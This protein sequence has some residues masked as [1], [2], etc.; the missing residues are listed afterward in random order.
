L[1]DQLWSVF[2]GDAT[3]ASHF[4]RFIVDL[5]QFHK[6]ACLICEETGADKSSCE[7]CPAVL[8]VLRSNPSSYFGKPQCAATGN[9]FCLCKHRD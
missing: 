7:D 1:S 3:K 6:A 2:Q 5:R 9:Q 4:T 8:V